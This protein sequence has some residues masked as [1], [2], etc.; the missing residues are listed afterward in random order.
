MQNFIELSAAV[1]E[2]SWVQR[3]KKTLPKTLQSVATARTVITGIWSE[4]CH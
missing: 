2:L 1:N 4:G 3:E